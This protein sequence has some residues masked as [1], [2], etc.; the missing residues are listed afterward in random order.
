MPKSFEE[1]LELRREA[2]DD[3][4]TPRTLRLIA[5][6]G[7]FGHL[8]RAA[9]ELHIVPSAASRRVRKLE[10]VLGTDILNRQSNTLSLTNVGLAIAEL[11]R[12]RAEEID[13]LQVDIARLKRGS[14]VDLKLAV[15]GPV[16]FGGLPEQL[17]GY[18]RANFHVRL[19]IAEQTADAALQSV[20][21]GDADVGIVIGLR[22][23]PSLDFALYRADHLGVLLPPDHPL[24]GKTA[25]DLGDIASEP[26]I[27][28]YASMIGGLL[29]EKAGANGIGLQQGIAV[30]DFASIC[31][32]V[33]GG[34]GITVLPIATSASEV[35]KRGLICISIG[36]DWARC[37]IYM[38]TRNTA[39]ASAE[40]IG[41][42]QALL[43]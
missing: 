21:A 10:D 30:N 11:A 22:S 15:S 18:L 32:M 43:S 7:R 13:A 4:L 27:M 6:I 8:S 40:I 33:E 39:D 28:P 1:G 24:C 23:S 2:L 17:R 41:L 20:L 35:S 42:K 19:S 3:Q 36:Y 37:D 26:L 25:L 38:V 29:E 5:A 16:I 31:R 9:E 14:A 12:H 34:L